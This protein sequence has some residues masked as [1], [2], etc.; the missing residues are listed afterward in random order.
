M[1]IMLFFYIANIMWKPYRYDIV[2]QMENLSFI[3]IICTLAASIA[4]AEHFDKVADYIFTLIPTLA[5]L[6]FFTLFIWNIAIAAWDEILNNIWTKLSKI[7][8]KKKFNKDDE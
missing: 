3:S 1:A 5:F 4:E 6:A 8:G 7:F 2:N